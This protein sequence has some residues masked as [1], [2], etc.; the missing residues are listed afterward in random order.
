M[1]DLRMKRL[2]KL[3]WDLS[4]LSNLTELDLSMNA[5][6]QIPDQCMWRG[7]HLATSL[8]KLSINQ[9]QIQKLSEDIGEMKNLK[10][11]CCYDNRL[12][13]LPE[14][15]HKL[16]NLTQLNV[17]N[18]FMT[19]LPE[20]F[21]LTP[22]LQVAY[23]SNNRLTALPE[24]IG[25]MTELRALY[26]DSNTLSTLP[27]GF[28]RL[29]RLQELT[30]ANNTLRAVPPELGRLTT[31]EELYLNGACGPKK[32]AIPQPIADLGALKDCYEGQI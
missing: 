4:V 5:Y 20:S 17:N 10:T 7:G 8:T 13:T 22:R 30:L 14:S 23:L 19:A 15:L 24:D 2:D 28:F 9:N 32:F 26:L 18:N 16:E 1:L 29:P 12:V 27:E 6:S 31:L 21:C 3:P 11:L 25:R